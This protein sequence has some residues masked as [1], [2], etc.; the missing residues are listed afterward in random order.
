M[1]GEDSTPPSAVI[2]LLKNLPDDSGFKAHW[3]ATLSIRHGDREYEDRRTLEEK[4]FDEELAEYELWGDRNKLLAQIVNAI[5]L[6]TR[7]VGGIKDDKALPIVG[8]SSW[9]G[10]KE[11]TLGGSLEDM[12]FALTG[13]RVQGE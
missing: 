12:V 11:K 1:R 2:E 10:A 5:N 7:F 8:P 6:N 9:Q 4:R 13:V 3:H